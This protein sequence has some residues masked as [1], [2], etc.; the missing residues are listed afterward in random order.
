MKRGSGP[1]VLGIGSIGLGVLG[2]VWG[3]ETMGVRLGVSSW[4]P[5]ELWQF[6]GMSALLS[7]GLGFL[8]MVLGDNRY[9]VI[10]LAMGAT[11]AVFVF[12]IKF[13]M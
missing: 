11:G 10:G 7:A 9:G 3:L 8:A 2:W 5:P 12:G 1:S 13:G 6:M 4:A